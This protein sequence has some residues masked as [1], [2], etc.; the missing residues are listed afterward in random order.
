MSY[1]DTPEKPLPV[2]RFVDAAAKPGEQHEYAVIAVNSV[3]LKSPP[4][5]AHHAVR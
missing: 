4:A 3:G 1:H 5:N 2:M